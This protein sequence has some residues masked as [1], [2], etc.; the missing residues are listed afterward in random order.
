DEDK[1]KEAA[2][3]GWDAIPGQWVVSPDGQ[4][5]LIPNWQ[6]QSRQDTAAPALPQRTTDAAAQM[7]DEVYARN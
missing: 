7:A 1:E 6:F 3:P 5:V 2:G 4:R